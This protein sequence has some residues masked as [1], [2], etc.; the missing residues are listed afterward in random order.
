V[1]CLELKPVLS[2]LAWPAM[3]PDQRRHRSR[4][5]RARDRIGFPFH[6]L[7]LVRR[8]T[9]ARIPFAHAMI[10][11]FLELASC[12]CRALPAKGSTGTAMEELFGHRPDACRAQVVAR[13]RCH[14]RGSW[15]VPNRAAI[16]RY[17]SF[18]YSILRYLTSTM[19]SM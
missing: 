3:G 7:I 1:G 12:L 8:R 6:H 9:N 16:A 2:W 13:G 4:A 10:I 11:M 17:S 14:P 15:I 5:R 19:L 18:L